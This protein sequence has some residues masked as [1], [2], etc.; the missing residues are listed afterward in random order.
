MEKKVRVILRRAVP[1]QMPAPCKRGTQIF[2][3]FASAGLAEALPELRDQR[4]EPMGREFT[5]HSSHH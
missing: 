1:R 2:A 5:V 4:M 3:R